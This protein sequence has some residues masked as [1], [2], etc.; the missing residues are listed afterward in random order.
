MIYANSCD[1]TV[2]FIMKSDHTH[3]IDAAVKNGIWS[4]SDSGNR[5]LDSAWRGRKP[6]E[7][8]V[9]FFSVVRRYAILIR[10]Q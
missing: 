5:V 4:S 7:T 8:I 10:Y 3:D 2:V 1:Q 9:I 6:G